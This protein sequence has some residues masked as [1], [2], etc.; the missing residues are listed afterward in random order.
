MVAGIW[1][2]GKN[3]NSIG[4]VECRHKVEVEGFRMWNITGISTFAMFTKPNVSRLAPEV[5]ALAQPTTQQYAFISE[6]RTLGAN[7][8]HG[9]S[10]A[11]IFTLL[12]SGAG[13]LLDDIAPSPS[14]PIATMSRRWER[15]TLYVPCI[16][17]QDRGRVMCRLLKIVMAR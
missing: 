10:Q 3:F 9:P 7:C 13:N 16:S 15:H 4:A 8:A 2:K 5:S 11:N 6:H 1:D 14:P 17:T 12:P